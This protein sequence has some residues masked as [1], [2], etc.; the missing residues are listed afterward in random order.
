MKAA[1]GAL[2]SLLQTSKSLI[3]AD[4]FTFTLR[5][6]IIARYTSQDKDV[7]FGGNTFLSSAARI[8]RSG[9]RTAIGMDPQELSIQIAA[10][11]ND[12]INGT[13]ILQSILRG[14]FF[15]AD[16]RL[17]TVYMPTWGDTSAGSVIKFIGRVGPFDYVN[18]VETKFTARS[19]VELLNAP[20]PLHILQPSCY[21]NLFDVGCGLTRASFQ[22]SSSVTGATT[23]N[24]IVTAALGQ[25]TGYFD[26]GV[27]QFTSGVLNG[28]KFAIRQYTNP[29]T[30]FP[31]YPLPQVP[32]NGDTIILVPGCDKLR[33]TCSAKFSNLAKYGGADFVPKPEA[34]L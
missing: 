10:T 28:W 23:V 4:L 24:Q 7:T 17:E 5:N 21:H 19:Y 8:S 15:G 33:T 18:E 16:V 12:L 9:I 11:V 13:P 2:I 30:I 31:Y 6:G 14:D 3:V 32:A 1:S 29:N 22:T 20:N 34:A 26:L 27:I 25:A